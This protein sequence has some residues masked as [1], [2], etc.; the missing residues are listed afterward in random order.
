[1][2]GIRGWGPVMAVAGALL[3]GAV[4]FIIALVLDLPVTLL[5]LLVIAGVLAGAWYG[6]QLTNVA[7]RRQR[8]G[9]EGR[10]RRE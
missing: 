6:M 3:A 2:S 4:A 1:M 7:A 9:D 10:G 5:W 8:I